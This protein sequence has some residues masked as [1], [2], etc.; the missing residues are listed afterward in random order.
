MSNFFTRMGD[1]SALWLSETEIRAD[2]EAGMKDAAKRGK[3]TK[4]GMLIILKVS[5]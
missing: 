3:D 2:L 4:L 5:F 1:G